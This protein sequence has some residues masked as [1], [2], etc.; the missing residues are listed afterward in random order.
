MWSEKEGDLAMRNTQAGSDGAVY[1]DLVGRCC[2]CPH[3]HDQSYS[4]PYIML[5]VITITITNSKVPCYRP[6]PP[7]EGGCFDDQVLI[8]KM[9]GDELNNDDDGGGVNNDDD[10]GINS[11]DNPSF[12]C[13]VKE[14]ADDEIMVKMT[15]PVMMVS[16]VMRSTTQ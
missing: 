10:E 11:G 15:M 13:T 7:G 3:D 6:K 14:V 9:A 16:M 1:G 8:D 5:V 4:T 12:F 2:G